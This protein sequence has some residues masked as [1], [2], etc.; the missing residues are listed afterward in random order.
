MK[1]GLA[2][3]FDNTL[4]FMFEEEKYRPG[5]LEAIQAFQERGGLFGVSTGRS[6]QGVRKAAL[7]DV[8]F[9]FYILA[10]GSL[11]LDK[12][13]QVLERHTVELDLVRDIYERYGK[14]A[15]AVIQG[16]DTVYSFHKDVYGL[17]TSI[18]SFLDLEQSQI[19]GISFYAG[20]AAKAHAITTEIQRIYGSCVAAYENTSVLDV[21]SPECSKGTALKTV[22]KAL[23]IDRMGAIGDSYNDVSMMQEGDCSFTF[24][25]APESVQHEV[26]YVVTSMAEALKLL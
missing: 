11:V 26:D 3:D 14:T 17:Q 13:L 16:D 2:S 5:D 20:T 21:V 24:P 10:T 8:A 18:Q 23:S 1:L 4:Y 12:N 15:E 7:D 22:K 25:Y 6:L 9:D 19:Y